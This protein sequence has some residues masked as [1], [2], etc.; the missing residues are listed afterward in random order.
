MTSSQKAGVRGAKVSAAAKKEAM[1]EA[2]RE[3]GK[4][5]KTPDMSSVA[6]RAQEIEKERVSV[7]L[8]GKVNTSN[9]FLRRMTDAASLQAIEMSVRRDLEDSRKL[10][11]SSAF[12]SV[13]IGL[14]LQ[15]GKAMVQHG[16][17]QGW[18]DATFPGFSE[19]QAQYYLKIGKVFLSEQGGALQLPQAS[20]MGTALVKSS[21]GSELHKAVLDFIGNSSLAELM[22]K[23][24]IKAKSAAPGGF[25]PSAYMVAKYQ[26][27][28]KHLQGIPFE[29]WT[30]A[31]QETFRA[32]Q[33]EQVSSPD[34]GDAMRVA[35]EGKWASIRE[36]LADHGLKR[37]SY[38]Y[39]TKKQLEETQAVLALVSKELGKA[40]KSK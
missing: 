9:S 20:E 39:L 21:D 37:K 17:W 26:G 34:S 32:W 19:R 35:S 23:H 24:G 2:A 40:L 28:H 33:Q 22:D 11:K 8:A 12:V 13:R 1:R 16:M 18:I 29:Q 15:A 5:G 6:H 10:D 27:E 14:A 25:R 38:V 4:T 7:E 36:G 3:A 30:P 31:D